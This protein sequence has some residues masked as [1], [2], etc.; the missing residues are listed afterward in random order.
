[1]Q[2]ARG[3]V[4]PGIELAAGM[5][6]G[7]DDFQRRFFRE[8]RVRI[9][10]NAAPVVGHGREAVLIQ[11]DVDAGRVAGDRLVH[12]IVEHFGEQMVQGGLVGAADIHA[13][14]PPHRLETLQHL[15]RGGV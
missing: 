11:R 14:A 1:M 15:D 4:G 6:R 5:Q 12:G 2:A 8:F 9:D 13:G 3:L 10:R 7:H